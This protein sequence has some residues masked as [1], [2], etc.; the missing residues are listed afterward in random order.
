MEYFGFFI[1]LIIVL[2]AMS[3]SSSNRDERRNHRDRYRDDHY[4]SANRRHRADEDWDDDYDGPY[5]PNPYWSPPPYP[6]RPRQERGSTGAGILLGF[7]F[8]IVLISAV[9]VYTW[10]GKSFHIP[11]PPK[12]LPE[13][14][15][16]IK[17][18][19]VKQ[20]DYDEVPEEEE[21]Q[22]KPLQALQH[23]FLD[24]PYLICLAITDH[25]TFLSIRNTYPN[26]NIEAYCDEGGRYW[27]GMFFATKE[28]LDQ[29]MEV[30]R[31]RIYDL[32]E[33]GLSLK[34]YPVSELCS[35][36][37]VREKGTLI[38]FRKSAT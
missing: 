7:L 5:Y 30:L 27:V 4:R 37:I 33:H 23:E 13:T 21:L 22:L 12:S 11:N 3:N 36:E 20:L 19:I 26:R 18:P 24:K 8:A 29:E 28:A 1:L 35:G 6:Y 16:S 32:E 31:L 38:W 34:Y 25:K 14:I 17:Q 10:D 2:A 9:A 15:D